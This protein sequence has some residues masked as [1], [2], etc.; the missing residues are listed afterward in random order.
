MKNLSLSMTV[1]KFHLPGHLL[2]YDN[3]CLYISC[4]KLNPFQFLVNG[5]LHFSIGLHANS[6]RT[7]TCKGT[8]MATVTQMGISHC[9]VELPPGP[10]SDDRPGTQSFLIAED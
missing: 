10:T 8:L 6:A 7:Q 5:E 4:A 1:Y 2:K 3:H 9:G